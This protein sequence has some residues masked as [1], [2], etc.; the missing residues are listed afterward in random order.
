[1]KYEKALDERRISLQPTRNNSIQVSFSAPPESGAPEVPNEA[2]QIN[3]AK[4]ICYSTE[5]R[6]IS[7]TTC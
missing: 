2:Q 1:M 5:H 7:P 6:A 4:A 3:L